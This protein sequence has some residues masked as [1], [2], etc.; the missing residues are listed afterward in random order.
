MTN[1]VITLSGMMKFF[2]EEVNTITTGELRCK[3]DFVVDLVIIAK[4]RATMKDKSYCVKLTL[5][6]D[7]RTG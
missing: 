3:A 6:G 1:E 4:I 2:K 5:D 7:G